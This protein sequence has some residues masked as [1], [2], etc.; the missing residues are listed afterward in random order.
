MICKRDVW[1]RSSSMTFFRGRRPMRVQMVVL[2]C[3]LAP[4]SALAAQQNPPKAK[5]VCTPEQQPCQ[6]DLTQL[7]EE[8]DQLRAVAKQAFDAEMARE[9][10]GD[11]PGSRSNYDWK[12]CLGHERDITDRNYEA[13]AGVIRST[14]GLNYPGS[15]RTPA[16]SGPEGAALTPEQLVAEFDN[17]ERLWASYRDAQCTAAFHQ[18]GG[19]SGATV[20]E[21]ECE[22]RLTRGHMRDLDAV[23]NVTS[24]R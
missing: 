11:C 3:L 7:R 1:T 5:K 15:Q 13:F 10:G 21:A 23:Y 19:G 24:P 14:L 20:A 18:F 22:Q 4:V 6:Q 8:S 9:K 2:S 16:S 17:T 12:L